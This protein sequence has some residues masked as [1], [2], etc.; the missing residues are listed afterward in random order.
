MKTYNGYNY[1]NNEQFNYFY[2]VK[3]TEKPWVTGYESEAAVKTAIDEQVERDNTPA[4]DPLEEQITD[5]QLAMAELAELV[6]G[7]N[8]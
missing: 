5:L 7:G 3:G 2:C 1:D 4:V 6:I 8:E